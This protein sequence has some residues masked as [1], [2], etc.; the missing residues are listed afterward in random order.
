[1]ATIT[2]IRQNS[3][4][5]LIVIGL[6]MGAFIMGD[7]FRGGG[8]S[9]SQYIG[10]ISGDQIDRMDYENRVSI[11]LESLRSISQ[12]PDAAATDQIRTRFGMKC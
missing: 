1:M 3:G 10:E 8:S 11:Q 9:Q 5:V 7:M 4:L 12:N 6:G 2:K